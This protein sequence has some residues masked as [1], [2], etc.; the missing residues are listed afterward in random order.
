MESFEAKPVSDNILSKEQF[1]EIFNCLS[2][3]VEKVSLSAVLLVNSTG[4]ILSHRIEK[5]IP[6]DPSVLAS[7]IAGSFSAST[8]T[9]RLLGEQSHFKMLLH[10]GESQSMLISAV[11]SD[12]FLVVIFESAVALGMIR[13][14]TKRTIEQLIPILARENNPSD[15]DNIFNKR[16]QSLLG[17]ELDRTL[18][19]IS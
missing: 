12:F 14:F 16:F 10:E 4:H 9:A 8:E 18:T 19:E 7:L 17:E 2:S 11:S 1:D 15:I 13:L 6:V 3:L 5:N